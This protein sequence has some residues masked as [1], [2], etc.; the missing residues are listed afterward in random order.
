MSQQIS[1]AASPHSLSL[2]FSSLLEKQGG[3]G[4]AKSWSCHSLPRVAEGGTEFSDPAVDRAG[5]SAFI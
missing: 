5:A 3:W 2:V 4:Q 1:G